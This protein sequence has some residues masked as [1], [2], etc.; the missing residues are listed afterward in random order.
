MRELE[1]GLGT[2]DRRGIGGNE[3][4]SKGVGPEVALGKM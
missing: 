3:E 4:G 1:E 2:D